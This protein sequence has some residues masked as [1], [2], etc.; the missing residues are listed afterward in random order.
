MRN[1]ILILVIIIGWRIAVNSKLETAPDLQT[2]YC[3]EYYNKLAPLN[4]RVVQQ[5]CD[6][7]IYEMSDRLEIFKVV[8]NCDSMRHLNHSR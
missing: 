1:L 6:D 5:T 8:V 4:K 7:S 3:F 2:C